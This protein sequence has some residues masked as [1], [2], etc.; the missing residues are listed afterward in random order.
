MDKTIIS[1]C[2]WCWKK[3]QSLMLDYQDGF[4]RALCFECRRKVQIK[5]GIA[6]LREELKYED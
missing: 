3:R 1:K 4:T 2:E 5:D 6:H